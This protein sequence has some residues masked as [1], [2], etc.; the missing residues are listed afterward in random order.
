MTAHLCTHAKEVI[1]HMPIEERTSSIETKTPIITHISTRTT[2]TGAKRSTETTLIF[3]TCL[4]CKKGILSCSERNIGIRNHTECKK[5]YN[6]YESLFTK[7][8]DYEP[9][10]FNKW[11]EISKAEYSKLT[12]KSLVLVKGLPTPSVEVKAIETAPVKDSA[13][14]FSTTLEERVLA[15]WSEGRDVDDEVDEDE[16][17]TEGKIMALLDNLTKQYKQQKRR[18]DLLNQL[19]TKVNTYEENIE[20]LEYENNAFKERLQNHGLSTK[21]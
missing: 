3:S 19:Q 6:L 1:K 8:A 17:S 20:R 13:V 16:E 9:F 10:I 7:A 11:K 14:S 12:D 21:A 5:S 2:V 18:N 15:M 4:H